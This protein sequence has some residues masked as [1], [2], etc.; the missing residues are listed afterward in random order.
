MEKTLRLGTAY[1][2]NRILK[3]VEADME[4]LVRYHMD[5][6]VHMY[7]HNDMDRHS[8]ILKEIIKISED[9]GLEVWVD[10]WGIDAGPGD[11]AYFVGQHPETVRMWTDGTP[12][13]PRPCYN[14]PEFRVFTKR[15]IEAVAEARGKTLFWDEPCLDYHHANKSFTC[16]CP[17]CRALFEERYGF[18]MPAELTAEVSAFRADTV[19]DYF[20]EMT[21]Y[22]ASLGMKN[23]GCIMRDDNL[24]GIGAG[25]LDL[26]LKLPH[27]HN[28]GVDPYWCSP[29]PAEEVYDFVY[30]RTAKA[31]KMCDEYKKD[32]NIWVKGYDIRAGHEDEIYIA[33]QAA[34]DAGARNI[35][36][37]SFRGGEPN[38]YRADNCDVAWEVMGEVFSHLRQ[39]HYAALLEEIRA[40]RERNHDGRD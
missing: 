16:Y 34:Y 30:S 2:G 14:H 23:T 6:V 40:K 10:N 36:T 5:T 9:K 13:G 26:L 8:K 17:L 24:R 25:S 29:L 1:H 32:H 22:A 19:V 33:A 12:C 4:D 21:A 3:H 20:S 7:T 37:W 28:L 38:N 31:L 15:W 18:P 27:F 39:R 11:K 35:F